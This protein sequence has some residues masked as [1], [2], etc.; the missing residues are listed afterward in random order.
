[1][2]G[3]LILRNVGRILLVTFAGFVLGGM[4][5]RLAPGFGADERDLNP[6]LSIESRKAL[7]AQHASDVTLT[8]FWVRYG[9]SILDGDLGVST[10]FERPVVNLIRE[11]LSVTVPLL[12]FGALA[13]LVIGLMAATASALAQS[14]TTE[15][16]ASG[17][18]AVLLSAPAV[19]LGL[20]FFWADWPAHWAVALMVAPHIY[21][22]SNDVLRAYLPSAHLVHAH[23]LGLQPW[24]IWLHHIAR[25]LAPEMC[26]ICGSAVTLAFGACI[27]IEVVCDLPGI[28]QFAW[29]SA[30]SRDL[31]A[32]V[33]VTVLVALLNSA[34]NSI[35]DVSGALLRGD[36]CL[37]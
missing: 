14:R 3:K 12:A 8:E 27:P 37:R 18:S 10:A 1:M 34:A 11:R 7:R 33:S 9:T 4:L 35:A 30:L 2:V 17:S 13:G 5:V 22:Y 25:P 26:S 31:P 6:L 16:L 24:R 20:F 36:E 15:W 32:V 21:R 19:L 28:G 29:K 23:A